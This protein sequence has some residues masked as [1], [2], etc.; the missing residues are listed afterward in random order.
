MDSILELIFIV[1]GAVILYGIVY[2][3]C[4]RAITNVLDK[5]KND[6]TERL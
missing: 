3:A 4:K 2:F 5:T 6:V 1:I